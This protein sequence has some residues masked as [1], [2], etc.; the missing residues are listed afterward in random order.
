MTQI[1]SCAAE[2]SR[3]V[4]VIV[5]MDGRTNLSINNGFYALGIQIPTEA[6]LAALGAIPKSDVDV[7]KT[8][9][10]AAEA[11]SATFQTMAR[12]LQEKVDAQIE[13]IED[14]VDQIKVLHVNSE[15][16][17]QEWLVLTEKLD[18]V[19]RVR[20]VFT[21]GTT[22]RTLLD[23]ALAEGKP[24]EL[25]VDKDYGSIFWAK[26][27]TGT[28]IEFVV[29]KDYS[30]PGDVPRTVYATRS[31]AIYTADGIMHWF[32]DHTNEKPTDA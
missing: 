11:K 16:S 4:D 10:E 27:R 30:S 5:R 6:L 29:C 19:R 15:K 21:P 22:G 1:R 17:H 12:Q 8:G 2:G 20:D 3:T 23:E 9:A 31:H 25:P 28:W 32:R 7:W 24:F 14:L 13:H 18:A 26:N